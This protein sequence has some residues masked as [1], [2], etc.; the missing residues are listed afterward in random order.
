MKG[1]KKICAND[2]FT[3]ILSVFYFLIELFPMRAL[4]WTYRVSYCAIAPSQNHNQILPL[5][6][7][8][9]PSHPQPQLLGAMKGERQHVLHSGTHRHPQKQWWPKA[10]PSRC[11]PPVP[12]PPSP[13]KKEGTGAALTPNSLPWSSKQPEPSSA[14]VFPL[15]G[16]YLQ[17][18]RAGT[19]KNG[20]VRV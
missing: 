5:Y 18:R 7:A 10:H 6:P 4:E 16:P 3:Y 13:T 17:Y 20:S 2:N 1:K 19:E 8:L 14:F 11:R 12:P 9:H 15:W